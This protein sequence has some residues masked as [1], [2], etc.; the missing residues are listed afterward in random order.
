MKLASAGLLL[1]LCFTAGSCSAQLQAVAASV[2][3]TLL[4]IPESATP[5]TPANALALSVAFNESLMNAPRSASIRAQLGITRAAYAQASVMPNPSFF[6][7]NDT[8]Q[9]ATQIGAA[10]PIELP[11]KVAFRF[12]VAK[13][14]VKQADL[15]IQKTLWQLRSTVRKAYLDAV[16]ASE[17]AETF[18][19]LARLSESLRRAADKR[20]A[21][22]DVPAL[23]VQR[24]D[25]LAL[26][27]E[28]DLNQNLS[29]AEKFKQR[30]AILM[31]R[32]YKSVL[33]VPRLPP[34]QLRAEANEL[35]PNFAEDVPPVE[36]LVEEALKTRLEVKI[37][38]QS[39]A[40]N[41]AS[42]RLA[43]GNILPNPQLNIGSS[44]SGNPP[45]GPATRGYFLGVTQ[46]IPVLNFQQG[47]LARL[48]ATGLQLNREL[49][50]TKNVVTEDVVVAYREMMMWRD[51]VRAFQ[52][53]LLPKAE[54]VAQM[55]K[56]GYEMGQTDITAA[57]TAQK[58]YV[59][60][61]VAYIDAVRSYQQSLTNLEQALGRPL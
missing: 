37:V 53:K 31:G 40:A 19:E 38:E 42:T 56:L 4:T 18:A 25:L 30:L 29:A 16:I 10:I 51:R 41:K 46:E 23:D 2:D 13:A 9:R 44:Y 12:L 58:S 24:A 1:I 7:L 39:I 52:A 14:Q 21:A 49:A 3:P 45:E 26:Q 61:K 35:V 5:P 20:F 43:R 59:E 48:K 22:G 36:K 54:K 11:W 34:F 6:F 47:E 57:I 50:S 17:S 33:E 27:A 15:E 8:A 28:A 60:T 32:D 55:S